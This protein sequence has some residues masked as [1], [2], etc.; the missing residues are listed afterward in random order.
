MCDDAL[1]ILA[2]T[3]DGEHALDALAAVDMLLSLRPRLSGAK[4]D[5]LATIVRERIPAALARTLAS[6]VVQLGEATARRRTIDLGLLDAPEGLVAE[7]AVEAWRTWS[8]LGVMAERDALR[9]GDPTAVRRLREGLG[10]TGFQP[11]EGEDLDDPATLRVIERDEEGLGDALDEMYA[12]LPESVIEAQAAQLGLI[13][14][15][16]LGRGSHQV[17]VC[18]WMR[19]RARQPTASDALARFAPALDTI[20]KN[21]LEEGPEPHLA[22]LAA[23]VR[24]RC[25]SR[26]LHSEAPAWLNVPLCTGAVALALRARSCRP[27]LHRTLDPPPGTTWHG[28]S[29]LALEAAPD[30]FTR[31]LCWLTLALESALLTAP[32]HVV[33]P[34]S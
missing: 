5:R 29:A 4:A 22:A 13:P 2:A 12:R 27:T 6:D 28:L 21:R 1:R 19:E 15:G 3:L 18:T 16:V 7:A 30:L 26:A 23:R 10:V 25:V 32:N 11:G 9:R 31:D 14:R 8:I 33:A 17:A 20:L 24:R 34:A